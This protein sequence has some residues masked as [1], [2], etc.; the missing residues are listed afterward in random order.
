MKRLEVI[1]FLL[2]SFVFWI[3]YDLTLN[4][5]NNETVN[6]VNLKYKMPQHKCK[7]KNC[8]TEGSLF[9]YENLSSP[10]VF[11]GRVLQ[12]LVIDC[13]WFSNCFHSVPRDPTKGKQWIDAIELHQEFD[14]S[15]SEY[16]V[17]QRHFPDH[18]VRKAGKRN[19]LL[20]G[21]VPSVFPQNDDIE[22]LDE[23]AECVK[24]FVNVKNV[25]STDLTVWVGDQ[26]SI[27]NRFE[28][29][30]LFWL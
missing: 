1:L 3:N 4:L 9:R 10:V 8:T 6:S 12:S 16:Y 22:Y 29:I 18:C 14:H 15:I 19:N 28:L 25:A 27:L 2:F 26:T 13:V 24:K 23:D 11:L 5:S 30:L 7:I 17:C 21:V 20:P